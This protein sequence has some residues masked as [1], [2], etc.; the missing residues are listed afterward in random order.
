MTNAYA[1]P[2]PHPAPSQPTISS[3]QHW[4]DRAEASAILAVIM[5][6]LIGLPSWAPRLFE[7]RRCLI[8]GAA[9]LALWVQP[10]IVNP[11]GM[12]AVFLAHPSQ[13]VRGLLFDLWQLL[14]GTRTL[15]MF[16][17]AIIAPLPTLPHL[18]LAL[19][20]FEVRGGHG[21]GS[22]ASDPCPAAFGSC[23]AAA[24]ERCRP[25]SFLSPTCTPSVLPHVC[26]AAALRPTFARPA[27][28]CGT[29]PGSAASLGCIARLIRRAGR[30]VGGLV[31]ASL[32]S[33]AAHPSSTTMF[34]CFVVRCAAVQ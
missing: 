4:K 1:I 15:A 32:C 21:D 11:R 30:P 9:R 31:L 3:P 5:L 6:L 14:L 7:R 13:G 24:G 33:V 12:Q 10:W 2:A 8:V 20:A 17:T 19:F 29:P 16:V 34:C 28:S 25:A 22:V 18:A 23:M 26:S 27:R